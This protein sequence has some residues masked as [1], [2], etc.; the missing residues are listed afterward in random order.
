MKTKDV[1]SSEAG[2]TGR[3]TKCELWELN[4]GPLEEY[5]YSYH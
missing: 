2:V 5:R 3:A 4:S 1:G